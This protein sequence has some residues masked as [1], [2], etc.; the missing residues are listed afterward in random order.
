MNTLYTNENINEINIENIKH[1]NIE[2]YL[3]GEKV[4]INTLF[5]EDIVVTGFKVSPSKFEGDCAY[6]Q[7]FK[8]K[9]EP[10]KLYVLQTGSKTLIEQCNEQ[11][12][13]NGVFQLF[14][15]RIINVNKN[16]KNYYAFR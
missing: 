11:V 7:F 12:D 10:R 4:K 6:I 3:Q 5:G 9:E 15:A 1:V 2:N 13:N 8:T 16:G 14:T